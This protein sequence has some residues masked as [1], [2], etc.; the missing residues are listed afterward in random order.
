MKM[1]VVQECDS[2]V[3]V[4]AMS[5]TREDCALRAA[6]FPVLTVLPQLWA[7]QL[8]TGDEPLAS[9]RAS[10]LSADATVCRHTCRP[11]MRVDAIFNAPNVATCSA[12]TAT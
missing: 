8:S 12:A 9:P 3:C 7:E 4:V 1:D 6:R 11:C 2:P 5:G 10:I